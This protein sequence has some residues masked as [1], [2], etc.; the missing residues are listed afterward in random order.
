MSEKWFQRRWGRLRVHG[1]HVR[2][3]KQVGFTV[4]TWWHGATPSRSIGFEFELIVWR[5]TFWVWLAERSRA[6]ES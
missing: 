4:R 2:L 3:G 6:L 1:N 5:L